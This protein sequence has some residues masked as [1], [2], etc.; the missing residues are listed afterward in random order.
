MRDSEPWQQRVE[1]ARIE[2][3]V[4]ALRAQGGLDDEAPAVSDPRR[5]TVWM[6]VEAASPVVGQTIEDLTQFL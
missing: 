1:P 3:F 5:Y 6:R 2:A 4:R